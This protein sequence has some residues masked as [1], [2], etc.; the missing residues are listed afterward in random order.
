MIQNDTILLNANIKLKKT[1]N[2]IQYK[3]LSAMCVASFELEFTHVF[4]YVITLTKH[5]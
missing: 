1:E 2:G 3:I 5:Y 4:S